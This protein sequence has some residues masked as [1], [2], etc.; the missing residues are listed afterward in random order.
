M[1]ARL[2]FL[3][4]L[5]P[6][7]MAVV[8]T[9]GAVTAFFAATIAIV[10]PDIKRVLAYSTIS[11]IGYMMLGVGVGAFAAG[12]FHLMTH[13]F[14]KAL[15]FLGAGSV[16]HALDGEQDMTRMGGLRHRLRLTWATMLIAALAL[17]GIPP[18]AGFFSKDRVLAHAYAGGQRWF[19]AV[20]VATAGFTALYIFRLIFM[21][22]HGVS[23]FEP[24]HDVHESPPVMTIP[25]VVLAVLSLIGGWAGLPAG[26]LWGDRF[27]RF[28]AP[29]APTVA[30]ASSASIGQGGLSPVI[31]SAIALA[32][33]L[34]GIAVAWLFYV[35]SPELPAS[36]AESL[37]LLY[38]VLLRKYY[39]DE[40]YNAVIGRP[41]FWISQFV[42]FRGVDSNV[43][44]GFV[45]GT[46]LGVEGGGA[47]LRRVE[48][49]NLQHYAFVYLL[50]ALA[51]AA[52]YVYL[53]MR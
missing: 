51:V 3:Y 12:I 5:S 22:F 23:R 18:F 13:A 33:A 14:F 11:Q 30:S 53:V 40:F 45:D 24:S 46:G 49:G 2:N 4:A 17:S 38:H 8:A 48:T 19:W 9:I 39:V 50:G 41:L 21:T 28:L 35:R 6:A 16:I 37:R 20:G 7:A 32:V 47:G 36:L 42:L 15:L 10:Q 27:E 29:V 34:G 43:I 1:I 52:Y 44:D 25:M 31:T 26:L